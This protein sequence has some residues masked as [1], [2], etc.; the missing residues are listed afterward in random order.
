MNN[1]NKKSPKDISKISGEICKNLTYLFSDIDDTIT[2]DGLI[3]PQAFE[4]IWNLHNAGIKVVP[5][6]GRP[7]GWCDHIAR[8]WPVEGIIGENGAFYFSYDR[9]NKKM[10][11]VYL[12][13]EEERL[14]HREK[15]TKLGERIIR[16][17]PGS[18]IAADQ[19]FRIADLAID[20]REDTTPLNRAAVSRICEIMED[21]G[22]NYKVSSIHV[23]C[24]FGEYDKL[25]CLKKFIEDREKTDYENMIDRI[26]F[27]GDSP[28]DEPMFRELKNTVA[29]ANIK[30]FL[31]DIENYPTYITNKP[32]GEGFREAVNII[33][34]KL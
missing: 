11:R 18:K 5:V 8:M 17:V 3:T 4:S 9:K 10:R 22:V 32:S 7:A 21:E 1:Q 30:Y 20:Y 19:P 24:W 34:S 27:I 12:L 6:T 33:L 29:V 25:T 16:E 15:L 28:N 14:Q 13:S 2:T 23:N 31:D 26:L